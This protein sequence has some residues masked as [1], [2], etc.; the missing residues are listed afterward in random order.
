M[1]AVV[2][3]SVVSF[4]AT[5]NFASAGKWVE[6]GV[7]KAPLYL[8]SFPDGDGVNG[9][10][11]KNHGFRSRPV[12]INVI[13]VGTSETD[14]IATAMADQALL[15]AEAPFTVTVAGVTLPACVLEPESF[16]ELESHKTEAGTY[17][18]R[19]TFVVS[20]KRIT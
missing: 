11:T 15:A 19:A 4:A 9:T 10:G 12:S 16:V 20:Q 8:R 14:P 5:A 17:W 7:A 2:L 3:G 13:Y 1:P 18:C 6:N